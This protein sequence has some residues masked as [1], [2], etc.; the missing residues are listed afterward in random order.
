MNSTSFKYLLLTVILTGWFWDLHAQ[1]LLY[2]SDIRSESLRSDYSDMFPFYNSINKETAIFMEDVLFKSI[3]LLILDENGKEKKVIRGK[4]PKLRIPE[5]IGAMYADNIYT[6]YF[7]D[8]GNFMVGTTSFNLGTGTSNTETMYLELKRGEKIIT[9]F[10]Y[11]NLFY[12]VI[13]QKETSDVSFHIY[14]NSTFLEK[15]KIELNNADFPHFLRDNLYNCVA[16]NNGKYKSIDL[17]NP[18][19][20][21]QLNDYFLQQN[22]SFYMVVNTHKVVKIDLETF[23]TKIIDFPINYAEANESYKKSILKNIIKKTKSKS[24]IYDDLFFRVS[25]VKDVIRLQVYN[26]DSGEEL[27]NEIIDNNEIKALTIY[28]TPFRRDV[29]YKTKEDLLFKALHTGQFGFRVVK[30]GEAYNIH[31]GKVATNEFWD[32]FDQSFNQEASEKNE[33]LG[34]IT[35][36]VGAFSDY[37]GDEP[38]SYMLSPLYSKEGIQSRYL[39]F[40]F[41]QTKGMLPVTPK[42]KEEAM[43]DFTMFMDSIQIPIYQPRLNGVFRRSGDLHFLIYNPLLSDLCLYKL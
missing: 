23:E 2:K 9:Q 26:I 6:S 33:R 41:D 25:V 39:E 22:T 20:A 1:N 12:F 21:D 35:K 18:L 19:Y 7:I 29:D 27:L 3:D 42:A 38:N 40:T 15:K 30:S 11:N 32:I 28:D 43:N 5:F 36:F 14:K 31:L 16:Y 10:H 37:K 13:L 4:N 34:F 24:T 17:L 8:K